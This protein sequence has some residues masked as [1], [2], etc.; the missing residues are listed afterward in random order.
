VLALSIINAWVIYQKSAS[1]SKGYDMF[2]ADVA[3]QRRAENST[4][5]KSVAGK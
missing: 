1:V 5:I 2:R 4:M 3:E